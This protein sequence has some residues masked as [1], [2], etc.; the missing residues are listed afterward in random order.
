MAGTD[1][2]EV[3]TRFEEIF[4]SVV[5]HEVIKLILQS[6]NWDTASAS[7]T[8]LGMIDKSVL[9]P[10]VLSALTADSIVRGLDGRHPTPHAVQ[11]VAS[12]HGLP[13]YE[14][15]QAKHQPGYQSNNTLK[16]TQYEDDEILLVGN[17]ATM[18]TTSTISDST[19]DTSVITIPPSNS[20]LR[21]GVPS[22]PPKPGVDERLGA[23]SPMCN[24]T[25]RDAESVTS[26]PSLSPF[27]PNK[28]V[29]SAVSLESNASGWV[30]APEFVPNAFNRKAS[31][32]DPKHS[33]WRQGMNSRLIS[34]KPASPT[35]QVK[36]KH[37]KKE[38]I[39]NKVL[40]GAKLMVLM[41][42]LPGSGKTTLAK[43]LKGPSG[44]V[45]STDDYFCDKHGKYIY[46]PSKIGDAHQWNKH[47]A[48]Q[49]LKQSRTPIIIDN[50][51]LQAWEMKPYV[52]LAL[53]YGYD[54]DILDVDTSWKLSSKELARRNTHG[55]PAKKIEEMKGRYERDVNLEDVIA[56]LQGLELNQQ[57]PNKNVTTKIN[58]NNLKGKCS[59]LRKKTVPES[60][61]IDK[62]DSSTKED[63]AYG[64]DDD[65][66]IEGYE[67]E[68]IPIPTFTDNNK[69]QVAQ[70]DESI[71]VSECKTETS[72][73]DLEKL[74]E[75]SRNKIPSQ[76][77]TS[78]EDLDSPINL[79]L[80]VLKDEERK[81]R[82]KLN[83]T[84]DSENGP[85][86][87]NTCELESETDVNDETKIQISMDET[88]EDTDFTDNKEEW[89]RS[90]PSPPD[91]DFAAKFDEMVTNFTS[92]LQRQLQNKDSLS[93]SETR[94]CTET[95][96]T[97]NEDL[98]M[99]D[100]CS[101][102][103]DKTGQPLSA[104]IT[105]LD[106]N[107]DVSDITSMYSVIE[108][109]KEGKD[110]NLFDNNDLQTS[111]LP[112]NLVTVKGEHTNNPSSIS[113]EN[114]NQSN[115]KQKHVTVKTTP[116]ESKE[117]DE[118]DKNELD[119]G[120]EE[121]T[122]TDSH[123]LDELNKPAPLET[124]CIQPDNDVLTSWECVDINSDLSSANWD[125]KSDTTE[126]DKNI[127]I[128]KACRTRPNRT[129]GDPSKWLKETDTPRESISDAVTFWV[130]VDGCAP[131]WDTDDSPQTCTSA[132]KHHT[133]EEPQSHTGAI[134][135]LR[136]HKRRH[137]S[138]S[139]SANSDSRVE[140]D[141]VQSSDCKTV[142]VCE[143]NKTNF[144]N[145]ETQTLSID[146]E[147]LELDHNLY[148]LKVLFGQPHYVPVTTVNSSFNDKGPLTKGE[149]KLDKGTMTD[150]Q[151]DNSVVSSFQNLV[152]FFPCIAQEDLR[153]VF[154]KCKYDSDWA[155]NVLL[156]S[157]YEM[158]DPSD[159]T[160]KDL[161]DVDI[162]TDSVS[163][164]TNTD[165]GKNDTSSDTYDIP[166]DSFSDERTRKIKQ[167]QLPEDLA[168]KIEIEKSFE[169][170]E[171]VDD[172]VLRLTG[173]KYNDLNMTKI[174][175]NQTRKQREKKNTSPS[176]TQ[177]KI[178]AKENV[179]EEGEG[180][181][182][183]TLVMD[184][185]FASQLNML[186]GPV[187]DCEISGDLTLED[188]SVVLPLKICDMIHKYWTRTVDGKF[189]HEAE[190][191]DSLVYQDEIL[192]RKLQDEENAA[193]NLSEKRDDAASDGLPEDQPV[194]FQEIMD[195]E[196]ALQES[197]ANKVP[198][199]TSISSQLNLRRL[200]KEY[201]HVDPVA[202]KEEYTR[203]GCKYPITVQRI[204]QRY[205]KEQGT[206]K[207]VI[208]PEALSRYE[209]Q[210]IEKAQQTSLEEQEMEMETSSNQHN[211]IVP[212]DPQVKYETIYSL[213]MVITIQRK[214]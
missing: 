128:P 105:K 186:F 180:A 110:C 6:C 175:E 39:I 108:L 191:L 45:L 139:P 90:T 11:N 159:I 66:I 209:Q 85:D 95:S 8:L 147:A 65:V 129:A 133:D 208:A 203:S 145:A 189:K 207:T 176:K 33:V 177:A 70:V 48:I 29:T 16:M 199:D 73:G 190:I 63:V 34:G 83:N 195:L 115:D 156:D 82:E 106:N 117:K 163:E 182:Y 40:Y 38:E 18:Y 30:L 5:E 151:H 74:S 35:K 50:T 146:F 118:K 204:N 69:M 127:H 138:P 116:N 174:K 161:T 162:E 104:L 15:S 54:I 75:E 187:G 27:K 12:S 107:E 188:R 213:V 58:K 77:N 142:T 153:D 143:G 126:S 60:N 178:E 7:D 68:I 23:N 3:L 150:N 124:T 125:S 4:G 86:F 164:T 136:K 206:P 13:S 96:D 79:T 46:E 114:S 91:E 109:S 14:E 89:N 9:P 168:R 113:E 158:S 172:R 20:A 202:L 67:E 31:D 76:V 55:V 132:S 160:A 101:T 130:A 141:V 36:S 169:F 25:T 148:E 56:D 71:G 157:G 92:A 212:D 10:H 47:R 64:S 155:M 72:S 93:V 137:N 17:E 134:S 152:A 44:I 144:D 37:S 78:I 184:P 135:K 43:E 211:E 59:P 205:G 52:Q 98:A 149:L 2:G 167:S 179:E 122:A 19:S 26:S 1:H 214:N 121:N 185:L 170:S 22:T 99:Y 166:S 112:T 131:Q 165:D 181:Q 42:G 100:L 28:N 111:N 97:I 41:R 87:T 173:K 198:E 123:T 49:R 102:M 197:L 24:S 171:S 103:E 192:A 32:M 88:C 200:Y 120:C 51:N 194:C 201:P 62:F 61:E 84:D 53:Q 183:V 119:L 80:A 94:D 154:E 196:Q 57:S 140:G 21:D 193:F 210:M 81:D